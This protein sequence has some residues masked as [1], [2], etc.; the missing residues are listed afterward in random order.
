MTTRRQT[1]CLGAVFLILACAGCGAPA[2]HPMA[3]HPGPALTLREADRGRTFS[4]HRGDRVVLILAST[5]WNVAAASDPAVL[6][7][8]GEPHVAGSPSGCVPGQGCGTVTTT[9]VAVSSGQASVSAS[10]S[11]CGEARGC[12]GEERTYQATIVVS[13]R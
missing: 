10:R 11:S 6:R 9:F 1:L 4:V 3:E 5:Y 8:D 13:G 12:T 7:E 2:G